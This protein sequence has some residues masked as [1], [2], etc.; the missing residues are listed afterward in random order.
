[1]PMQ[2]RTT[3][4]GRRRAFTLI[5][6]LVSVG[7]AALV[8]VGIAA[9]FESV[10]KTV[11]GGKR[12]SQFNAYAALLEQ[13]LRQD[14]S[15]MSREGFLLIRQQ[16]AGVSY[17]QD[18]PASVDDPQ[19]KVKLTA[20]DQTGGR[21]RRVDELM[22]F[23]TGEFTTA[24][25]PM[26]PL[27]VA[28]ASSARVYYGHGAK[29][30]PANPSHPRP[31]PY[32]RPRTG[33]K[34]WLLG[35]A[36]PGGTVL[37]NQFAADWTLLRQVTLLA[38]PRSATSYPALPPPGQLFGR[39]PVSGG[40][41]ADQG[42]Q[43]A[44]QPAAASLFRQLNARVFPLP[45]PGGPAQ[46][47]IRTIRGD[48]AAYQQNPAFYSGIIDLCST[49]L[50]DVRS[51]VTTLPRPPAYYTGSAKWDS[52]GKPR[53]GMQYDATFQ[54]D[55]PLDLQQQWMDQAWPVQSDPTLTATPQVDPVPG[56]RM[57]YET[58][59]TDYLG[60][61][62]TA[63]TRDEEEQFRRIDQTMLTASGFIPRCTEFIVE[64]SF[65]QVDDD[66]A[67]PTF[68]QVIWYGLERRVDLDGDG[69][70]LGP[71]DGIAA[72]PYPY[73]TTIAGSTQ[74]PLRVPYRRADGKIAD[75]APGNPQPVAVDRRLI[76]GVLALDPPAPTWPLTNYFGYVDPTFNP[77]GPD[78]AAGNADDPVTPRSWAWPR[79]IRVTVTIADAQDPTIEETFQFVIETPGNPAT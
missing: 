17:D 19:L 70:L 72:R 76:N 20:E 62:G 40:R 1:M 11:S 59:P 55:G 34:S 69:K 14:F 22:F 29:M 8:A 21:P 39:I 73:K 5:E 16:Y 12:V 75:G 33:D 35:V 3:R 13:Q 27:Y 30:S 53:E 41:A 37:P 61:L 57:R 65:G 23:T 56:A 77:A 45:L 50:S 7:A 24:R 78:G 68:G 28:R 67:S 60:V 36:G 32:D 18:P 54:M 79:L 63:Y 58:A 15:Q 2:A 47:T 6:V 44:L 48:F 42:T 4:A 10:G 38:P 51:L 46:T 49:S 71:R 31:E 64:W 74:A 26:H 25:E 9:I 66:S 43:I 52:T